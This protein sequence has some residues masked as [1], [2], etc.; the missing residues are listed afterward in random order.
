MRCAWPFAGDNQLHGLIFHSARVS[1]YC[2]NEVQ[3]MLKIYE[4]LSSMS[5]KADCRDNSVTE[6]FFGSLKTERVF[7]TNNQSLDQ[8]RND[9]VDFIER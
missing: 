1:Q 2:S 3:K 5:L 7:Y 8:A 6:S 4:I 9:I